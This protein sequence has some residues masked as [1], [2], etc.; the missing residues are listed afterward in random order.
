MIISNELATPTKLREPWIDWVRVAGTVAIVVLHVTAREKVWRDGQLNDFEW[1]SITT[2]ETV[3]RIA[4]PLFFM[5]SG[6]LM[7][8][9]CSSGDRGG[10]ALS[11]AVRTF[12]LALVWTLIFS[13]WE[14]LR[15]RTDSVF[16]F[17]QNALL[18]SPYYHL[19]FLYAL[20]LTYVVAPI[21]APG[22]PTISLKYAHWIGW[23]IPLA[24]SVDFLLAET[25]GAVFYRTSFLSIGIPFI[26]LTISGYLLLRPGPRLPLLAST[27]IYA[28]G[29]IGCMVAYGNMYGGSFEHP[30]RIVFSPM[31]TAVVLMSLGAY[32]IFS[33]IGDQRQLPNWLQ[34]FANDSLA[35]YLMHPFVLDVLNYFRF[36]GREPNAL[37]GIAWM[38]ALIVAGT[39]AIVAVAKQVPVVRRLFV[40]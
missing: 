16:T 13:C 6:Y 35:I 32:L 23:L 4:V 2:Y 29:F 17:I 10:Y 36:Y 31:S 28:V 38:S 7:L 34:R 39:W 9:R 5:I 8:T 30:D 24:V 14:M 40:I 1:W 26:S 37:I 12:L 33:R 25:R 21:I 18:G 20:A 3:T 15:G 11:R 27:G 19:W 22:L